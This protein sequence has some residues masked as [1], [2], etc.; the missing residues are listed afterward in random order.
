MKIHSWLFIVCCAF[1][2]MAAGLSTE[3]AVS[4]KFP[5]TIRYRQFIPPDSVIDFLKVCFTMQKIRVVDTAA[6]RRILNEHMESLFN[7][8][9]ELLQSKNWSKEESLKLIEEAKKIPLNILVVKFFTGHSSTTTDYRFDSIEWQIRSADRDTA[10]F[11]KYKP[12]VL[13]QPIYSVLK[14]FTDTVIAS[15]LL[16]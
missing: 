7:A 11:Y 14:N 10:L 1:Y 6:S 4:P 15:G 3:I 12:Q 2:L 5:I 8:Q 13:G 9:R 16:R